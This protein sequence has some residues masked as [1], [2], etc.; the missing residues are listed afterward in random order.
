MGREGAVEL[1][2]RAA[3][4]VVVSDVQGVALDLEERVE[5][6]KAPWFDLHME[7]MS[8]GAMG[9]DTTLLTT[10]LF[11]FIVVSSPR[12]ISSHPTPSMDHFTAARAAT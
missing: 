8:T 12:R 11:F 6:V 3:V 2:A 9:H 10:F 7:V 1:D 5:G 4:A